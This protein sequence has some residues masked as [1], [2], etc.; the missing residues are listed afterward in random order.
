MESTTEHKVNHT[1]TW[2]IDIWLA[3]MFVILSPL[4]FAII[5]VALVTNHRAFNIFDE[6]R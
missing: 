3:C 5:V 6:L 4:L 1:P 2:L